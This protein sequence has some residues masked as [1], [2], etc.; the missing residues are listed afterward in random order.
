[1][2]IASSSGAPWISSLVLKR[3]TDNICV[4]RIPVFLE[5]LLCVLHIHSFFQW[6]DRSWIYQIVQLPWSPI[7]CALHG[8]LKRPRPLS[9]FIA[10]WTRA[11][12]K[13]STSWSLQREWRSAEELLASV[14]INIPYAFF[15]SLKRFV[16]FLEIIKHYTRSLFDGR[17]EHTKYDTFVGVSR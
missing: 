9:W 16:I 17:S 15:A 12:L 13:V 3:V 1:M 10:V 4:L 8:R 14:R 6:P 11:N 7:P 5:T 2:W